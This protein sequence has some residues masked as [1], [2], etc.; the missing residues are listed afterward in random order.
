MFDCPFFHI[1]LHLIVDIKLSLL[2]KI[3]I[4]KTQVCSVESD[5]SMKTITHSL[6]HSLTYYHV[7][8]CMSL[9]IVSEHALS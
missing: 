6:T 8:S 4:V 2:L 1:F 5:F 7:P 9:S 3:A